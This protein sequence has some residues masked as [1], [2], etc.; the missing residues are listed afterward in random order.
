MSCFHAVHAVMR[1]IS[2]NVKSEGHSY[3]LPTGTRIKR[4]P[5]ELRANALPKLYNVKMFS[6]KKPEPHACLLE[7]IRVITSYHGISIITTLLQK[8]DTINEV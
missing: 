3:S 7:Y 6:L 2:K 8:N 5:N 4:Y 1:E